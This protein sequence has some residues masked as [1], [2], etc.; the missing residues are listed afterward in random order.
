MD[1]MEEENPI[2]LTATAEDFENVEFEQCLEACDEMSLWAFS[3]CFK[4]ALDIHE[5]LDSDD[6]KPAIRIFSMLHA[7]VGMHFKP[8]DSSNPFV[9][10]L[11]MDGRRSA[12]LDDFR[13]APVEALAKAAEIVKHPVLAA[14][15]SD[16]CWM[17]E[18]N[19]YQLGE[20]AV[21]NYLE[22]FNRIESG[23]LK[24][25]VSSDI[26]CLEQQSF[27]YLLRAMTIGHKLGSN[28]PKTDHVREKITALRLLAIASNEPLAALSYSELEF[29]YGISDPLEIAQGI[30]E[31]LSLGD[32]YERFYISNKLY[33]LAAVIYRAAGKQDDEKRCRIAAAEMFVTRAESYNDKPRG[34]MMEASSLSDAIAA[35]HG[36]D[37][38]SDRRRELRHM[39]V[40]V[41]ANISDQMSTFSTE[42]DLTEIVQESLERL[43]SKSLKDK[44]LVFAAIPQPPMPENLREEAVKQIYKYPLSSLFGASFM[45]G[46][47]KTVARSSSGGFADGDNEEAIKSQIVDGER[48]RRFCNANAVIEP[49]R[50][51]IN[52]HHLV[53]CDTFRPL[54]I[55]SPFVPNS[56]IETYAIGFKRFF[57]GDL[58]S[59]V[60]ILAPMLEK[61]LRQILKIAGFDVTT[62][63]DATQTQEDRTISALFD[64]MRSELCEILGDHMVADFEHT[65]LMKHGPNVRNKIA[66]GL[67]SDG[68]IR[69]PDAI[70]AC[71]LIFR[72]CCLPILAEA[73]QIEVP[74]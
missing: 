72:L 74:E 71:W 53:G 68:E 54:L 55:K 59:A 57:E 17:L 31:L 16:M 29:Q 20:R 64:V 69:S 62:F 25:S 70:Y 42:I 36:I 51:H 37:G 48:S 35:Y 7:A 38:T 43:E 61:S 30:D 28:G 44:L 3:Q 22:V 18:R 52:E 32:A 21:E 60:H 15:L 67:S 33:Q 11:V 10:M 4:D 27:E 65:F 46:E 49:C 34:A 19:R 47:G 8:E 50:I 73:A 66:H 2:W 12:A 6:V 9:P 14:H 26:P 40:D 45:D 39:L 56:S 13:G 23:A 24:L 1:A 5:H 58:T 41:Q 63:D